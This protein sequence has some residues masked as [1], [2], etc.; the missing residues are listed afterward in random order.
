MRSHKNIFIP[1]QI[2]INIL[3]LHVYDIE[4]MSTQY[5]TCTSV[6]HNNVE[7]AEIHIVTS[8]PE[9]FLWNAGFCFIEC[10]IKARQTIVI[11]EWKDIERKDCWGYY[12]RQTL[13][14]YKHNTVC[15]ILKVHKIENFFDSEF[16]ICVISLL[17]MHK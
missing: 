15:L 4:Y 11:K 10:L 7:N 6:F 3:I 8:K 13:E 9:L 14:Q 2:S 1:C 16:G 12:K 17:L 5:A